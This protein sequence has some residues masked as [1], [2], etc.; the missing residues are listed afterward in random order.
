M[1]TP[2]P[3]AWRELNATQRDILVLLAI[4]GGQTGG[5]LNRL[6]GST[7]PDSKVAY[8]NLEALRD[9]GLVERGEHPDHERYHANDLTD[10]GRALVRAAVVETARRVETAEVVG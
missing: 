3:D 9:A 10:D 2:I 6:L 8:T 1:D 7:E 4:D 5:E